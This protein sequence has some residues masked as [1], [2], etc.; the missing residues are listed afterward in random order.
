MRQERWDA[1]ATLLG[2]PDERHRAQLAEACAVLR[3]DR[4][5]PAEPVSV[6]AGFL[7]GTAPEELE[8]HYTRTFDINPQCTLEIGWHL[9]G[10][11]YA[12]GAFLVELRQT[13]RALGVEEGPELPDHLPSVL[14]ALGRM[15]E[16]QAEVFSVC[17]LQPALFRM[18]GS[19]AEPGAPYRHLLRGVLAALEADFGPTDAELAAMPA[20]QAV[21]YAC[22]SGCPS[23]NAPVHAFPDLPKPPGGR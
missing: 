17:F 23:S 6:L 4:E 13:M 18:I 2:Y 7:E 22:G 12:R 9:Y 20:T 1:V 14:R 15:A 8:E 3:A 16:P 10:E 19:Y 5:F 21:P 11:D